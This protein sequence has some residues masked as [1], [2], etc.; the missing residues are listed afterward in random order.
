M[1]VVAIAFVA[2]LAVGCSS[3]A[4]L[5]ITGADVCFNC[6]RPISDPALAGQVITN[7]N[8]A[9]KFKSTA[10]MVRWMKENPEAAGTAKAIYVT[11]YTTGRIIKATSA[12]FV[13]FVLVERYTKTQ[14]YIAFHAPQN[15]AAA[16]AEHKSTPV[17]WQ[18]VLEKRE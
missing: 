11:D 16:A 13:P 18:Q 15:A 9:L 5:P 14:D 7:T 3:A 6:R 4:P 10:C 17:R 8:Q 12:T 1:R 2:L